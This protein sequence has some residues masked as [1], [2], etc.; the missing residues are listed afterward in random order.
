MPSLFSSSR[1]QLFALEE[2]SWDHISRAEEDALRNGVYDTQGS[3]T[4]GQK[5]KSQQKKS[6]GTKILVVPHATGDTLQRRKSKLTELSSDSPVEDAEMRK[7]RK[8]FEI[9]EAEAAAKHAPPKAEADAQ[10][11]ARPSSEEDASRT[12]S[13]IHI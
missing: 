6:K 1:K 12:L 8:A 2:P 7:L 11:A 10:Q 13:L 5:A 4:A 3:T 9:S